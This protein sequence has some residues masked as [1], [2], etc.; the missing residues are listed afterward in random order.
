MSMKVEISDNDECNPFFAFPDFILRDI[1]SLSG[2]LSNLSSVCSFFHFVADDVANV[3]GDRLVKAYPPRVVHLAVG[4]LNL[5]NKSRPAK[6][7]ALFHRAMQLSLQNENN[8]AS[9]LH[10]EPYDLRRV[11]NYMELV[12]EAD[13]LN[14]MWFQCFNSNSVSADLKGAMIAYRF[15]PNLLI[16]S[17]Q[18]RSFF[19]IP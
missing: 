19:S 10:L 5:G 11:S 16:R 14:Q 8:P 7:D 4:S 12:A 9:A 3:I 18:M 17:E 1:F 6:A 2:N 13:T 15:S